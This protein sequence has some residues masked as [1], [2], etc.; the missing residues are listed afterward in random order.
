M[1]ILV[2]VAPD[3]RDS[4]LLTIE[5]IVEPYFRFRDNGLEVVFASL[6]GGEPI[7]IS[8]GP[9]PS[10]TVLRFRRDRVAREA[11]TDT[12]SLDQVFAEDFQAAYCI[13]SPEMLAPSGDRPASKLIAQ[14]LVGGRP[15]AVVSAGQSDGLMITGASPPLAASALIGALLGSPPLVSGN[16]SSFS[17]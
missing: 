14:L 15:V 3:C 1:R 12:L 16:T 5:Q 17:P 6:E 10:D 2:I 13:G 7:S 11:L 4:G 8:A 9:T